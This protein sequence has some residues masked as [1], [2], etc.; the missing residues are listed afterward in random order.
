[1]WAYNKSVSTLFVCVCDKIQTLTMRFFPVVVDSS[2]AEKNALVTGSQY[3]LTSSPVSELHS[4]C[5]ECGGK[6]TY[7]TVCCRTVSFSGDNTCKSVL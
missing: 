2:P 3:C 7:T 6:D 4:L 5:H 1:V